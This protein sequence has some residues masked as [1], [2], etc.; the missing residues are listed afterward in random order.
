MV[1]WNP[2]NDPSFPG[3]MP[4]AASP[5]PVTVWV[6]EPDAF[7]NFPVP[8]ITEWVSVRPKERSGD[9]LLGGMAART[10]SFKLAS[11]SQL[12]VKRR[13]LSIQDRLVTCAGGSAPRVRKDT[14]AFRRGEKLSESAMLGSHHAIERTIGRG[15]VRLGRSDF[16]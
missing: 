4:G 14:E 6:I 9:N 11:N 7:A 8:P 2:L 5:V 15:W 10:L 3:G 16:E 13:K 12:P 1:Y